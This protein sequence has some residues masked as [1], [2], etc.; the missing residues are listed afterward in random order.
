MA[1]RFQVLALVLAAGLTAWADPAR[2][3]DFRIHTQLFVDDQAAAVSENTTLFRAG[4]VYDFQSRP[5]EIAIFDRPRGDRP[6]RFVLLDRTRQVQT[7]VSLTE[8]H[9]FTDRLTTWAI[10]HDDAFLNFLARPD[11]SQQFDA[12]VRTWTFSSKWLSYRIK[13]SPAESPEVFQQFDDFSGWFVRLNTM[14]SVRDRPPYGLAR[15]AVNK[16]LRER[17]ELPQQVE[18]TVHNPNRFFQGEARFR[19]EHQ[20]TSRLS[21]TDQQWID[22]A[23]T[24]LATYRK[25][26]FQEYLTATSKR[27]K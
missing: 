10:G 16:T 17:S 5:L 1:L 26:E 18:L 22:Q 23:Q 21:Q 11:F 7:E 20:W 6:G 14:L 12:M 9:Q 13:T 2:G 3:Q 25:L 15:L 24:F 27:D 4:V 19:T 8:V